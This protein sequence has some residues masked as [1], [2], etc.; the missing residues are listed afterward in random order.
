MNTVTTC[1]RIDKAHKH[2]DEQ[3]KPDIKENICFDYIHIKFK[4]KINLCP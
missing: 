4:T 1:T 2:N 3:K